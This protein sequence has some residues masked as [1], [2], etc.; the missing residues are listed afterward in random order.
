MVPKIPYEDL[1]REIRAVQENLALYNQGSPELPS[2]FSYKDAIL[3]LNYL[4][5][6]KKR[7]PKNRDPD[8]SLFE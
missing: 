3:K 6:L 1:V 4:R 8:N 5:N 7:Y 2:D